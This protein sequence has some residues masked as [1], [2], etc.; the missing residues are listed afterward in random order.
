MAV[1]VS[2]HGVPAW[3]AGAAQR[4][5]ALAA[6]GG[7]PERRVGARLGPAR[8]PRGGHAGQRP[9]A[10]APDLADAVEHGGTDPAVAVAPGG[11]G[12]RTGP[13][14]EHHCRTGR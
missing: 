12:E 10:L 4:V 14:G 7:D 6:G 3:T 9:L 8:S 5:A 11:C 13:A 2:T 1:Q